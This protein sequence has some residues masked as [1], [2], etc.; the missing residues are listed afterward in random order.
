MVQD[1]IEF[2]QQKFL[3]HELAAEQENK[4]VVWSKQKSEQCDQT[5]KRANGQASGPVDS[6]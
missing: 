6:N 4:R 3:S 5:T 1:R 2:G